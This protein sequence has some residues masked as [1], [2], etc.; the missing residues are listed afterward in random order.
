[1]KDFKIISMTTNDSILKTSFFDDINIEFYPGVKNTS[2]TI[3]IFES[4]G[5]PKDS[6]LQI[7]D[8]TRKFTISY[9]NCLNLD[10]SEAKE[11]ILSDYAQT[12]NNST[13]NTINFIKLIDD[14]YDFLKFCYNEKKIKSYGKTDKKND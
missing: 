3:M 11:F 1:M 2:D 8:Y 10:N 12:I 4:S 9:T 5:N 13:R 14:I 7:S 6:K